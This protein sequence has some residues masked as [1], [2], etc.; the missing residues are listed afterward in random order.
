MFHVAGLL[1]CYLWFV[2]PA[3]SLISIYTTSSKVVA[4]CSGSVEILCI[5]IASPRP[6]T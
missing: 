1:V 2:L 4:V 6:T 5:V 3:A